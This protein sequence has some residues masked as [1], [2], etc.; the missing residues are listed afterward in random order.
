MPQKN[1]ETAELKPTEEISF[2]ISPA[3]DESAEV[4]EPRE[5]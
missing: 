1:N 3:A 2:V 4:V 5:E